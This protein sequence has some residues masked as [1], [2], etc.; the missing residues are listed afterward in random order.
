MSQSVRVK[1]TGTNDSQNRGQ[2]N[3]ESATATGTQAVGMPPKYHDAG[4]EPT[5]ALTSSVLLA[6]W[7]I[8]SVAFYSF[9]HF[10]I[11]HPAV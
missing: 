9:R 10:S 11:N 6:H 7:L 1:Y 8:G 2:W 3:G 4:G 5:E